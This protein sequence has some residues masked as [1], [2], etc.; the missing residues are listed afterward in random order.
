[1]K[2]T[3]TWN[4]EYTYGEAY[5][6]IVGKSV[7][8]TMS[9]TESWMSRVVGYVR[10]DATKGGQPERGKIHGGR[11]G[12]TLEFVKTMPTAYMADPDGSQKETRS[13][14]LKRTY[15]I[16]ED[17]TA[18]HR[19]HYVGRLSADGHSVHGEWLIRQRQVQ[20]DQGMVELAG[21]GT[22]SARRIAD[23]PSEV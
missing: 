4:G 9:L 20:T 6:G 1:M 12:L 2:V 19:I 5:Q 11:R 21:T 14:W 23:L 3:G 16:E 22:W 8:F 10:D 18:P 7:P 15:G 17:P 13:S